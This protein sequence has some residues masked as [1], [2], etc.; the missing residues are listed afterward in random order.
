[1][2]FRVLVVDD[3]IAVRELIRMVLERAGMEVVGQAS[4]GAE[5]VQRYKELWPDLVTMDLVMPQMSGTEA[6]T[7]ILNVD[8]NARIIAVSG[9]TQPSVMAEAQDVG[10][11]GFVHKPIEG[12][13]LVAEIESIMAKPAF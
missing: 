5:A 7:A 1:V 9:L 10:I 13:E 2:G 3:A 11:V 12:D 8:I 4:N 6:A